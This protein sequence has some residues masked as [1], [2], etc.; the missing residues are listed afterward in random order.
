[1]KGNTIFALFLV[2]FVFNGCVWTSMC[3]CRMGEGK[4]SNEKH[5][6]CKLAKEN[7]IR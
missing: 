3:N 7:K 2:T 1:M 5:E 4:L 6:E